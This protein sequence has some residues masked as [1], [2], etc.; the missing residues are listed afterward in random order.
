[1][2]AQRQAAAWQAQ[3]Q[4]DLE[5]RQLIVESAYL[6][7]LQG[8]KGELLSKVAALRADLQEWRAKLEGQVKSYKTEVSDLRAALSGE[9]DA[10][11]GEFRDLK[12]A[13]KQQLDAM[14]SM[15]AAATAAALP[16]R[17]RSP[18]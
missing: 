6:S 12:A 2:A 11:R 17:P 13:L 14:A 18:R 1:M 3:E 15:H 10:L 4:A 16:Q 7:E 8:Q 5:D 9:V